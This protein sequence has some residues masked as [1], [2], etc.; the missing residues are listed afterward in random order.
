VTVE[1]NHTIVPARNKQ[2][3]AAFLANVLNVS[4]QPR[5]G[6]FVPVTLGNS[7]TLDYVDAQ[8]VTPQHYAFL[9]SDA[10]F[11]AAHQRLLDAGV[12]IWADPHHQHEG[13]INHHYGGRGVYF[14]DPEGHRMEI[15]TTPYG[16]TP[17]E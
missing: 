2:T 10:E 16:P 13:E 4:L 5:W 1:L 14:D 17:S 12:S 6:P 11:D 15:I 8:D 7:V 9:V 3:S